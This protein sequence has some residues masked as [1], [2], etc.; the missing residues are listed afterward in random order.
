MTLVVAATSIRR[1]CG[2]SSTRRSV[3]GS[4][5]REAARASVDGDAGA[6]S[7]QR[8]LL[9][10]RP[11]AA[12]SDVRIGLVGLDRKDRRY[13]AFEVLTTT[14]GGGF[15]SRLDQTLR[16]KMGITYGVHAGMDWRARPGRSSISTRDR[17]R[18]DRAG[19]R[20]DLEILDELAS[21]RPAGRR[22]SRSRSR[23]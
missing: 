14:L 5:R 11:D 10:D 4:S 17:H 3:R 20:G 23:T 2:P 12:Q 16:E 18:G 15:T 13:Y 7:T 6:R 19:H 1:R 22:S 8:L 21:H 9:V